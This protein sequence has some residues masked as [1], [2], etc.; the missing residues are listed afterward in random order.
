MDEV[1]EFILEEASRIFDMPADRL[2]PD[3]DLRKVENFE[4]IRIYEILL[5][6]EQHFG[7]VMPEEQTLGVRSIREF[8][9]LVVRTRGVQAG[10]D[11]A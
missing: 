7:I 5:G 1:I 2:T 9:E 10:T 4:S 3:M 8:A 6:V 11:S